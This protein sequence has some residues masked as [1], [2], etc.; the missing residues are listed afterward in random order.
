[1]I[2]CAARGFGRALRV[3]SLQEALVRKPF[4]PQVPRPAVLRP[5]LPS[6][7]VRPVHEA[8]GGHRFPHQRFPPLHDCVCHTEA[9]RPSVSPLCHFERSRDP[10]LREM[11]PTGG[12]IYII[13]ASFRMVIISVGVTTF[14]LTG[15]CFLLLGFCGG[16]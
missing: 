15:K 16:N 13:L 1:M 9:L 11:A 14:G 4:E 3:V 10:S 8:T 12:R 5:Q 2:L 7:A 6:V